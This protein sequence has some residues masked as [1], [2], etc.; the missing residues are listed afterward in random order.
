MAKS[1]KKLIEIKGTKFEK[2]C[3][4]LAFILLILMIGTMIYSRSND[5]ENNPI[6]SFINSYGIYINILLLLLPQIVK[7]DKK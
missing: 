1:K 7:K 6:L 3:V 4:L 5:I 2:I